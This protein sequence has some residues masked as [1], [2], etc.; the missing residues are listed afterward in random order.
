MRSGTEHSLRRIVEYDGFRRRVWIFG[1]RC[2][3]GATGSAVA[4]VACARLLIERQLGS[5]GFALVLTGGVLM[6]HD[7]KDHDLWF[8]RGRGSQP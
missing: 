3:H 5:S 6:A 7:W 2:H 4:G 8:E 1:Q